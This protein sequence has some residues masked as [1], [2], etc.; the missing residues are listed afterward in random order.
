MAAAKLAVN[1]RINK[2]KIHMRNK[3][4]TRKALSVNKNKPSLAFKGIDISDIE[5]IDNAVKMLTANIPVYTKNENMIAGTMLK[6]FPNG[7]KSIVRFDKLY[8]EILVQSIK[9]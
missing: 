9:K 6:T 4:R 2:R 5:S 1:S 8:R 3:A 7:A